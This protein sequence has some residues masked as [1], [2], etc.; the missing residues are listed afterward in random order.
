MNKRIKRL[1][2]SLVSQKLDS[3]FISNQYNVSYLTGF[4]G[5]SPEER[6]GFLF[7]S[8]KSAH[9]LTFPTYFGLFQNSTAPFKT[10]CITHD[11]RLKDH[12]NKIIT[13][14]NLKTMGFEKTNLTVSEYESLKNKLSLTLVPLDKSVEDQRITKDENE[15]KNIRKAAQITDIAFEFILKTI[16]NGITE[17][18]IAFK[19]EYFMKQKADIAFS[20]IVA[21]NENSAIPHYLT[22]DNRKLKT[23]SLILLDFGAKYDGYCSDMTRVIFFGK[24]RSEWLKVYNI[25]LEAQEKALRALKKGQKGGEIDSIARNYIKKNN[26]P[27]YQHGLGHGVGLGIHEAPRLKKDGQDRLQENMVVTV[28]PGIYLEGKFGIRIEDLS[29]IKTNRIEIL[30]KSTKGIVIL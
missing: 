27:D 9:L 22:T 28:E 11:I 5:L 1:Q 13:H 12:L 8:Q 16:K 2:G 10:L 29:V 19:L 23:D 20:P 4:S 14:E 7:V 3:I 17:K 24:P 18:D 21:F 30:S 15:I 26:Y 25:V 6:E